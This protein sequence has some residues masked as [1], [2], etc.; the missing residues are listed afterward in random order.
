MK[1]RMRVGMGFMPKQKQ[2]TIEQ[3]VMKLRAD[4]S[5]MQKTLNRWPKRYR[6]GRASGAYRAFAQDAQTWREAADRLE[7]LAQLDREAA[8]TDLS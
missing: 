2:M 7:T 8:T 3:M 5:E 6:S 4:A 1:Q